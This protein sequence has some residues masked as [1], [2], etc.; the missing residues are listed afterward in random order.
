MNYL[1]INTGLFT[2]DDKNQVDRIDSVK[3]YSIVCHGGATED[4]VARIIQSLKNKQTR[5]V[6]GNSVAL[7]KGIE[8]VITKHLCYLFNECLCEGVFSAELKTSKVALF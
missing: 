2:S 5:V 3:T 4:E 7:L 1:F 6:Y 8:S